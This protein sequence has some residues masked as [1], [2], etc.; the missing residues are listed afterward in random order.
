MAKKE[1]SP[2]G[3]EATF[4]KG[5]I[6]KSEQFTALEKDVLNALISDDE[7]CTIAEAKKTIRTFL[8]KEAN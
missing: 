2:R 7:V 5:Q 6:V 3:T 4:S 8:T 1:D